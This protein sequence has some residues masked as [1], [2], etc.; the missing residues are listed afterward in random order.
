MVYCFGGIAKRN[1]DWMFRMEPVRT[2]MEKRA[3][4][5]LIGPMVWSEAATDSMAWGGLLPDL[6]WVPLPL[7]RRTRAAAFVVAIGFHFSNMVL[8]DIG[9]FPWL[10]TGA[11]TLFLGPL[12]RQLAHVLA[13]YFEERHALERVEVHALGNC[14][15]N[16]RDRALLVDPEVDLTQ[17]EW[18]WAPADWIPQLPDTPRASGIAASPTP[19]AASSSP[20]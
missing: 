15:L 13:D 3:G 18:S 4:M 5:P 20:E 2:W 11:T 7:W 8:F 14:R 19:G 17:V 10:M 6:F 9:I 16:G 1:P 12:P